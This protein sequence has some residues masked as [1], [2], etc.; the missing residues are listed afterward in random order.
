MTTSQGSWTLSGLHSFQSLTLGWAPAVTPINTGRLS[1][2][3]G[4]WMNQWEMLGPGSAGPRMSLSGRAR[5]SQGK[6]ELKWV[7]SGYGEESAVRVRVGES[8]EVCRC[9][10]NGGTLWS[11][12]GSRA[13]ASELR[14]IWENTLVTCP[15]RPAPP[16]P[17]RSLASLECLA[18]AGQ[19]RGYSGLSS[20][21]G[22]MPKGLSLWGQLWSPL[23]PGLT[24]VT[25]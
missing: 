18:G 4:E 13:N 1:K 5:T 7:G 2:G 16:G 6:C 9:R 17:A 24:L 21:A 22:R 20:Q 3:A 8:P 12:V 15:H 14:R 11:P 10:A 23:H 25:T 19:G